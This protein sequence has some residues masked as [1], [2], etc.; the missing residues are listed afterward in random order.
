[1]AVEYLVFMQNHLN[2]QM[3]QKALKAKKNLDKKNALKLKV[4][5]LEK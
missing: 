1:M 4:K 3:N 5:K 2:K